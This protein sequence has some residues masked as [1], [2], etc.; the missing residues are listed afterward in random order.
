MRGCFLCPRLCGIDRARASGACRSGSELRVGAVVVHRG[1]EPPLV[2]GSGS[3]AV[4]FCGCPMRCSYCQNHQIS[5]SCEGRAMTPGELALAMLRLE[6]E[7]CSNINLVSPTHYTPWILESIEQA[8]ASGMRLPVLVNSSGYETRECL[9]LWRDHARIYLMDLKY[10]DNVAGKTLSG[11]SD[12]WDVARDA[13]EY[14]WETAGPLVEDTEGRASHGLLVRH[15]VLPGM[16]SNPF[17]VLEFLSGLSTEIPVS[18]MSQYNPVY[19]RGDMPD[20][21]RPLDAGEYE[22]VLRKACD[23][24]F[25]TVF[26]QDMGA[27]D[28]YNPDFKADRPFDDLSRLL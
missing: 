5:Q 7:G 28:T 4:F 19:Y 14:L 10:G 9:H 25:E 24:G 23:L 27:S 21:R 6:G 17:S 11:V 2:A 13:I 3:G 8:R 22:A 1:E 15:L 12:Y 16:I 18:I 26:C 20:M